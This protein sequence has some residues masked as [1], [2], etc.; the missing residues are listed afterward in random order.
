MVHFCC[1]PGCLQNNHIFPFSL[2]P[3]KQKSVL[4][5]WIHAIGRKNVHYT[6]VCSEHFL[7]A[8]N[9]LLRADEVPSLRIPRS[10]I[11]Q[12][13]QCRERSFEARASTSME[14]VAE[15]LSKDVGVQAEKFVSDEEKCLIE[16]I[17]KLESLLKEK[18][19]QTA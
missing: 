4:K 16:K 2:F 19:N 15:P 18:D 1:V 11:S 17:N 7:N 12:P 14:T 9:R 6:R 10:D 8:R 3:L 5:Q 13:K